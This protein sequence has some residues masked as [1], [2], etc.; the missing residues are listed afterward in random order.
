MIIYHKVT[1]L[2]KSKY[3]NKKM[4]KRDKKVFFNISYWYNT[5]RLY[6]CNNLMQF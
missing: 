5:I 1:F 3:K 2:V 6:K 4:K